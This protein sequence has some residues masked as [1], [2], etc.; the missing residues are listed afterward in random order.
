MLWKGPWSD[1]D[2]D[3]AGAFTFHMPLHQSISHHLW[4]CTDWWPPP[5]A[6]F[7]G[8]KMSRQARSPSASASARGPRHPCSHS[9]AELQLLWDLT[10]GQGLCCAGVVPPVEVEDCALWDITTTAEHRHALLSRAPSPFCVPFCANCCV[11]WLPPCECP[12]SVSVPYQ[13]HQN[14][15]VTADHE[16]KKQIH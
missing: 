11:C 6:P 10:L 15:S 16:I 4:C 14:G 2:L 12:M 5:A 1:D 9:S 3:E 8:H 13:S 7:L